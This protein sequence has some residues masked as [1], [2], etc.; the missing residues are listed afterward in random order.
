MGT[1]IEPVTGKILG[2][3]DTIRLRYEYTAG[4]AGETFLR[5]LKDGRILASKC[6]RCG[7]VRIP[8]RIYCLECGGR[9]RI[10]V[11][12]VHLGWVGAAS[13][14]IGSA[15]SRDE[16]GEKGVEGE[17]RTTTVERPSWDSRVTFGYVKFAGVSGG[18]VHRL[19]RTGKSVPQV[20]EEVGPIFVPPRDRKGSILD[21]E[22]FRAPPAR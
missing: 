13:T 3:R 21:I 11:R 16:R 6:A 20:G 1:V 8:P 19:L 18:L 9:T 22:G 17:D 2:W 5:A 7:E 4:I 15:R 12:V 14:T 10:D